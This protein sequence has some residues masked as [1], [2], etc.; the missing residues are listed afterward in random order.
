MRERQT[1]GRKK[2]GKEGQHRLPLF[3][4]NIFSLSHHPLKSL[5]TLLLTISNQNKGQKI[6]NC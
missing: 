6:E 5:S 3:G 1:L 2:G 4:D